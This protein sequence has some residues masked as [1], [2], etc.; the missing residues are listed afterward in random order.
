MWGPGAELGGILQSSSGK[1]EL[2]EPYYRMS[3]PQ[4]YPMAQ[5]QSHQLLQSQVMI[6]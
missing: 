2:K 4:V 5:E 1:L 3:Q 6:M